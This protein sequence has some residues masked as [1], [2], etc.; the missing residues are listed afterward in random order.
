MR[1]LYLFMV[2]AV[3]GFAFALSIAVLAKNNHPNNAD[4]KIVNQIILP[5]IDLGYTPETCRAKLRVA[6]GML[7]R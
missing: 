3:F 6:I 2:G 7:E 4:A 1:E 5:C